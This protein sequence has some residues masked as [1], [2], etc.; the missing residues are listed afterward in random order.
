MKRIILSII[1]CMAALLAFGQGQIMNVTGV[2]TDDNGEP[3]IG[4]GVIVSGTTTGVTTDMDGH[5]SIQVKPGT[6]LEFSS[7]GLSSQTV[8]VQPGKTYYDITLSSDSN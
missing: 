2:V 8:T 1:L 7:L 4:A 6:V 5:F 3:V